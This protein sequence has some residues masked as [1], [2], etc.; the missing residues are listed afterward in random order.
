MSTAKYL[1]NTEF[2]LLCLLAVVLPIFEAPKNITLVLIFVVWLV[3]QLFFEPFQLRRPDQFEF[4]LIW[5]MLAAIISTAINWPSPGGLKGVK[6]T[7]LW[8][9]TCWI[10]YLH[11]L[12]AQRIYQLAAMISL[13][14][15]IGL[16]WGTVDVLRGIHNLLELNSV[17]V[18]TQSSIYLGIALVM[19]FGVA[20]TG[21]G[22]NAHL[23]PWHKWQRTLWWLLT[24]LML[25]GLFMMASRGSILAVVSVY[26][27][28][29]LLRRSTKIWLISLLIFIL[30]AGVPL[31]LP[32]KFSQL[33]YIEKSQQLM[34]THAVDQN[35]GLRLNMWRIGITQFSQGGSPVFGIGPRNFSAIDLS[36]L[37]FMSP[38]KL[39]DSRLYHAHNLFLT[40]LTEEGI[41]GLT[42]LVFL[43]YLVGASLVKDWQTRKWHDWQWFAALGALVVP[44]IAGSFN[45]PWYQEHAL[46]AMILFGIYFSSRKFGA[47]PD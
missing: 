6:D 23:L 46:L 34:Q 33:R 18:V 40:K 20:F 9:F 42:A 27:I 11:N 2:A 44:I 22:C 16:V 19:T 41:F 47:A 15:L 25:V 7:L 8:V 4:A 13:G 32:N 14:V 1:K 29:I 37:K 21:G 26:L 43:F 3:R 38:L 10:V 35:D 28:F 5:L 24:L 31:I 17:G 45:T 30:A 12:S 39:A 36:K